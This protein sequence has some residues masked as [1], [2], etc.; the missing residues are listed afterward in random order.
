MVTAL[1]CWEAGVMLVTEPDIHIVPG[2]ATHYELSSGAPIC[3]RLGRFSCVSGGVG[4][5][6]D[7]FKIERDVDSLRGLRWALCA[8]IV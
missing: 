8:P 1:L 4:P 6:P 3:W 7:I 2:E 5:E